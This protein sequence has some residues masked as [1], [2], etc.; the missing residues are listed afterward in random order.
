MHLNH[1]ILFAF[2]LLAGLVAPATCAAPKAG[3][4]AVAVVNNEAVPKTEFDRDW[5]A[6]TAEQ[7]KIMTPEQMTPD[8]EKD[9]KRLL[10]NQLIEQRLVLQEARKKGVNVSQKDVDAV[11]LRT[12]EKFQLDAQGK[13]L[14]A[15]A[16]QEAFQKELAKEGITEKQLAKNIQN[17]LLA[18]ALATQLMKDTVKAPTEEQVRKLFDAVKDRMAHPAA[19]SGDAQQADLDGLARDFKAASAERV[20]VQRVLFRI[21]EHTTVAQRKA[22]QQKAQEAKAKLD[23]GADFADVAEQY[24]EDK[25]AAQS[26]GDIGYVLRGEVK[27]LDDVLFS[28]PV[29]GFSGVVSTKQGY[30]I[31]RIGEKRA[32]SNVR[33]A[34]ARK[35]LMDYL[36][37][38]SERAE[39]ARFVDGLRKAAA[40][41]I[42]ASFAKS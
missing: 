28:L 3:E 5:N 32:A 17:Q 22:A 24:S 9:K 21:D 31:F 10:L 15:E 35:F 11:V 1:Q 33:Y 37:R 14:S 13:P 19:A 4:E 40:I 12:K 18:A 41:D 25:R 36:V 30:Q 16:A 6:F 2:T 39:Y 29:G 38:S 8:W 23:Q 26:G 27:D 7:E 34:A 20:R 42:K